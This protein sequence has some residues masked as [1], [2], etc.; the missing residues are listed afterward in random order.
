MQPPK[1]GNGTEVA[2]PA[3]DPSANGNG[4]AGKPMI[5]ANGNAAAGIAAVVP[6]TGNNVADS[7]AGN[8]AKTAGK[9]DDK[10]GNAGTSDAAQAAAPSGGDP[11]ANQQIPAVLQPVAVVLS[12][13][14]IAAAPSGGSIG[15]EAIQLAALSNAAK[16]GA[17][18]GTADRTGAA[19]AASGG[20]ATPGGPSVDGAPAGAMTPG[21]GPAPAPQPSPQDLMAA[22]GERSP[23]IGGP[24]ESSHA[25]GAYTAGHIGE[26]GAA[27][28]SADTV[29]APPAE[30][31]RGPAGAASTIADIT[32]QAIATN[33]RSVE[34]AAAP[35]T[36]SGG[37]SPPGQVP[38]ASSQQPPDGSGSLITPESLSA[39]ANQAAPLMASA[40]ASQAAATPAAPMAVPIAGLAVEIAARAHAGKNRFDIRLDPPELGRIDVRLD[41]DREG[42]VTSHLV[43]ERA[44]TLAVLRRDAPE[45]ERSL[46]QAGLKTADDALHFT[47]RDQG[48]GHQNPN[49]HNAAPAG[50]LR[51][52][53]PDPEL[54]PVDAIK[55]GYGRLAGT[56]SGIDIRV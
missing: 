44:E 50:T 33:V 36:G 5:D 39:S 45:L 56:G 55:S 31:S 20:A 11:S 16:A 6:N 52:I 35:G 40:P 43:V 26:P 7:N 51:G 27:R 23:N 30:T 4:N 22:S 37:E 38:S 25:D 47:L 53:V 13:P 19:G 3:P 48:F 54:P 8:G 15:E 41:V 46:Q 24:Q 2:G 17:T 14:V 42:K 34:P 21:S 32:Q 49:P 12:V 10:T 1:G 9:H 29:A 18:G 28:A